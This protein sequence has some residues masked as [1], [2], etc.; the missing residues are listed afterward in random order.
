[1]LWLLGGY[2]WLYIHRPFEVWP[3]LGTIRLERVYMI[4]MLA[5]WACWPGRQWLAN[6]LNPAYLCFFATIVA[7]WLVSPY[8]DVGTKTVEDYFKV[9]VFFVL[10]MSSVRTERDLKRLIVMYVAVVGL[11]M[12]HS[13]WEYKNGRHTYRMGIAR[14]VGV[15]SNYNDPNTFGA[16]ILYSLPMAWAMWREQ[17]RGWQRGLLCGYFALSVVCIV[18]TGSRSGFA[19]LGLLAILIGMLSP[20]RFRILLAMALAAPV[21]WSLV[22]PHMQNRFL[23]LI[24]PSYGPKNA[25]QSA[26][27]RSEGWTDGVQ[28]WR[29]HPMLGVGP[30]AFG[31]A[32]GYGL[33]SHHL[34][35]QT[36]GELGSLGAIT[37]GMILL[38]FFRN[39]WE[40][41]RL[42][43]AQPELAGSFAHRVSQAVILSVLMLLF[44]GFAGHNLYR[45]SWMWFGA[46]QAIALYTVQFEF[47]PSHEDE[48]APA[49][50]AAGQYAH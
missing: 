48:P 7:S 14:M 6:R 42:A 29:R 19:G 44:L 31:E 45:Y 21:G 32:R 8:H 5:Y 50:F 13:L 1:M 17:M 4:L 43:K 37:F 16:T 38:G 18:L 36:I 11:Y 26:E 10:V 27:S 46:F 30:F 35:G 24:D 34:Y 3:V 47:C 25:Q 20:Y 22:P 41:R 40:M 33:Q 23:T 28:F 49:C 2:M 12:L 39:G 15:D 9:A